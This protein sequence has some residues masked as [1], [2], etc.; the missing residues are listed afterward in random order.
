MGDGDGDRD[1]GDGG[2]VPGIHSRDRA[3]FTCPAVAGTRAAYL[4]YTHAP[5]MHDRCGQRAARAF[6]AASPLL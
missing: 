4:A 3:A 6:H 5:G 1:G 2:P